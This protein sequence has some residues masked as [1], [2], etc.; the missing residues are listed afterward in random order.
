MRAPPCRLLVYRVADVGGWLEE[1]ASELGVVCWQ[2]AQMELRGV[3]AMNNEASFVCWDGGSM[4]LMECVSGDPV[5]HASCP[6]SEML[7]VC[8]GCLVARH[9]QLLSGCSFED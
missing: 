3:H 6:E 7:C 8:G 1:R 2:G 5:P 4:H 9:G